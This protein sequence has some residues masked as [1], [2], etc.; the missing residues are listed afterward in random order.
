MDLSFGQGRLLH[1]PTP[2]PTIVASHGVKSDL[3]QVGCVPLFRVD[4]AQRAEALWILSQDEQVAR[5][6]LF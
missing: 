6:V 4:A 3:L 1:L 2:E 5:S